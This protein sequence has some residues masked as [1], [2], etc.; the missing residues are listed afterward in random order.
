LPLNKVFHYKE[1]NMKRLLIIA[2]IF[3]ASTAFAAG[4]LQKD[5]SQNITIQGFA[6]N[7]KLNQALTANRTAVDF[8]QTVAWGIYP[9]SDCYYTNQSTAT[10]AGSK[11]TLAGGTTTIRI[12][13]SATPYAN[14]T[15]CSLAV[16]Q[17]Q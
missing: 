3:T 14:F 6:P 8:R 7:G 11:I 13:N 12:V 17:K 4:F 15:G 1:N 2:A 10:R 16:L 9:A 5:A